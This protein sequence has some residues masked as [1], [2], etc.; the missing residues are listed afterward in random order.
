MFRHS[1]PGLSEPFYSFHGAAAFF[2]ARVQLDL[3]FVRFAIQH[4]PDPFFARP[5]ASPPSS[6][7]EQLFLNWLKEQKLS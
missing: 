7:K 1:L 3:S 4:L 5:L 6:P 2:L